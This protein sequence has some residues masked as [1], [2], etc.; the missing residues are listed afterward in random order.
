MK[1]L[2][3]KTQKIITYIIVPLGLLLIGYTTETKNLALFNVSPHPYL[4]LSIILSAYYGLRFS[5][6]LAPVLA[7]QYMILLHLQ[8]DYEAIESIFTLEYLSLPLTMIILSS[9]IG[10]FKT[11]SNIKLTELTQENEESDLLSTNLINKVK[12]LNKESFE[13][14]KQLVNKLDTTTSIFNT[15]KKL[16]ILDQEKLEENYKNI[17]LKQAHA[18]EVII[19]KYNFESKSYSSDDNGIHLEFTENTVSDKIINNAI[20]TKKIATVEDIYSEKLHIETSDS[21][22]AVPLIIDDV[23]HSIVSIT[24]MPFLKY[25]PNNFSLIDLYSDWYVESIVHSNN[26]NELSSN[27]IFNSNLNIYTYNFFIERSLEEIDS[28]KR[29]K[30]D[31]TIISLDLINASQLSPTKLKHYRKIISTVIHSN[32]RKMD[33]IT[34]GETKNLFYILVSSTK[35]EI[36]NKIISKISKDIIFFSK[37]KKTKELFDIKFSTVSYTNEEDTKELLGNLV[38]YNV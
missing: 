36:I 13:L 32:T 3:T 5:L 22:V 19:Y 37:N 33:C 35:E 1:T 23:I 6:I 14:K 26:F 27:S 12:F 10:E 21:L 24:K 7:T 20:K 2:N 38:S 8:T 34:E 15:V 17:L 9:I 11:R 4:F 29:N 18:E 30:S 31:F 16:N 25:T 28:A